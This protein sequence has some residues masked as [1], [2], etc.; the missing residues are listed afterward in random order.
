MWVKTSHIPCCSV[1]KSYLIPCDPM[2]CST[3]G[4][5]VLHNL[6]E[7]AQTNSYM[8]VIPFL[9]DKCDQISIKQQKLKDGGWDPSR[10]LSNIEATAKDINS[11]PSILGEPPGKGWL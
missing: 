3:P 2:D 10:E 4:F 5:P 8:S 1:T 7:F 11:L 9:A 6:L